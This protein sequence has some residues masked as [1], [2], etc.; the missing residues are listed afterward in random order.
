MNKSTSFR[1]R[2]WWAGWWGGVECRA[3]AK[4]VLAAGVGATAWGAS[5]RRVRQA[6]CA[7]AHHPGAPPPL[8]PAASLWW[9][10]SW[11]DERAPEAV[12]DATAEALNSTDGC[13]R[14]CFGTRAQSAISKWRVGLGRQAE[15]VFGS[16][17]GWRGGQVPR[18]APATHMCPP[19]TPPLRPQLLDR[20]AAVDRVP[21]RQR[22]P[23]GPG[24]ALLHHGYSRWRGVDARGDK[25]RLLHGAWVRG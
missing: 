1:V 22:V 15:W 16:G 5:R 21:Q 17:G 12:A 13:S 8:F 24:A 4:I 10:L 2:G 14:L 9:Y 18:L 7:P 11:T 20:V 19:P 25:G 23:A 6:P 3:W